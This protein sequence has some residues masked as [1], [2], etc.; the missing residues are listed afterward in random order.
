MLVDRSDDSQIAEGWIKDKPCHVT[1][2][3]GASVTFARPHITSG[4]PE[5]VESA[6]HS[7]Y[8]VRGGPLCLQGCAGIADAKREL[9]VRREDHRRIH[10]GTGRPASLRQ[11][12][13]FEVPRATTRLGINV[14]MTSQRWNKILAPDACQR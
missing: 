9:G 12:R 4:L 10:P 13:G 7:P 6:V 11:G 2:D 1:I 8:G 14:I 3:I 5:D